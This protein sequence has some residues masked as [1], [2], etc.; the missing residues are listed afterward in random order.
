[1]EYTVQH[2][3]DQNIVFATAKGEW[4]AKTDN[5]MVRRIMQTVEET[6]SI[7]VMLD[8]RELH[9]YHSVLRVFERAQ[10]VKKQRQEFKTV[11]RRV[12]IVYP[13]DNEK[14]DE[15]LTFFETTARNRGLPYRAFTDIDIAW[16]WL[17]E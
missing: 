9:F 10:E 15:N 1:M 5:E 13:V 8:I 14:I 6:G 11:S 16:A 12:A 2:R 17:L 3:T 4:N 7:K